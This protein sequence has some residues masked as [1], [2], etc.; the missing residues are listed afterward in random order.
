MDNP[1][2]DT[3]VKE[4]ILK[5]IYVDDLTYSISLRE[6]VHKVV[7]SVPAVLQ[8]VSFELAKFAINHR[9]L[10]EEIPV[11]LHAKEVHDFPSDS[12]AKP[13]GIKWIVHTDFSSSPS[14]KLSWTRLHDFPCLSSCPVFFI[15]W[16]LLHLVFCMESCYKMPHT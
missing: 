4:A 13:L 3:L 14:K 9:L 2:I 12:V 7:I 1:K 6:D 10:M 8:T 16:A 5:G 11:E 15:H